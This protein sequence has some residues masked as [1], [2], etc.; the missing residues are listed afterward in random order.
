MSRSMENS[1]HYLKKLYQVMNEMS[2]Y[3]LEDETNYV[4]DSKEGVYEEQENSFLFAL[5][6]PNSISYIKGSANQFVENIYDVVK[7]GENR[8]VLYLKAIDNLMKQKNFI[9]LNYQLSNEFISEDE[10][11]IELEKNENKYLININESL[12]KGKLRYITQIIKKLR[13][14]LTDD[15]ISEMFSIELNNISNLI[16]SQEKKL[17]DE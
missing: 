16:Q 17:L 3:I 4:S 15:D 12:N 6:K 2:K 1:L 5:K 7:D 13:A 9:N 14:D 8:E 10:Y 11:N